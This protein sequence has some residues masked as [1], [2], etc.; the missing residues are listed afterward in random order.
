MVILEERRNKFILYVC[1]YRVPLRLET[2][3]KLLIVPQTVMVG[4]NTLYDYFM[5]IQCC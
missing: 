4:Y 1:T 3:K 5:G 2:K